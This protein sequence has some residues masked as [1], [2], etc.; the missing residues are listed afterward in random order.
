M[1]IAVVAAGFM[2]AK[3]DQLRRNVATYK[4]KGLVNHLLVFANLFETYRQ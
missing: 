2:P 1:T 3:A 4:F